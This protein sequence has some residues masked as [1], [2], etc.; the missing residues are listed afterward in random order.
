M[1]VSFHPH[2]IH[3]VVCLSVCCLFVFVSLL[4]LFHIYLSLSQSICSLFGTS[5]S[6]SSLPRVEKSLHSRR[7]RSIAPWR[8]TIL[9]Q[10]VSPTFL[11]TSTSQKLLHCS[12]QE[13][14]GDVETG[15][16][17]LCDAELG[18]ETIGKALFSSLFIQKREEPQ[19]SHSHKES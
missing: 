18:D 6:M 19:T 16:S 2:A 15:H 14:S 8:K 4:F 11:T 1:R 12:F 17:Y 5:S 10:V 3:E 7:M 9:P 13:E